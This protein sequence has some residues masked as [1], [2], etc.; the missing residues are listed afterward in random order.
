ML[1]AV[2]DCAYALPALI[3]IKV[4]QIAS[5]TIAGHLDKIEI[6]PILFIRKQTGYNFFGLKP[7][8]NC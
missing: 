7:F 6:F 3:M 1:V 5:S 8:S 4:R 2:Q